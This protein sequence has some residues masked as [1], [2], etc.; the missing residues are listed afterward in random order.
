MTARSLKAENS[1]LFS[2]AKLL[3]ENVAPEQN[4]AAMEDQALYEVKP[5][6]KKLT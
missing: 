6:K 3:F 1:G 4:F 2:E 5:A